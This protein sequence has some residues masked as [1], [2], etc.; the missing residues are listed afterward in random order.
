MSNQFALTE[1]TGPTPNQENQSLI[2][3]PHGVELNPLT[4]IEEGTQD[5]KTKGR[6]KKRTQAITNSNE[7]NLTNKKHNTNE[8]SRTPP[9][10]DYNQFDDSVFSQKHA[11]ATPS[12]ATNPINLNYSAQGAISAA[13]T[14]YQQSFLWQNEG[15]AFSITPVEKV[16]K[17]K[18]NSMAEESISTK[19]PVRDSKSH[20]GSVS[21][22]KAKSVAKSI[23][24]S[25]QTVQKGMAKISKR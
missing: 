15:K 8:D 14:S 18:K 11:S 1:I 24:P 20:K 19:N 9:F 5:N 6:R 17:V 12:G 23:L 21:T 13:N 16:R 22:S 25:I 2:S 4:S 7:N 10:Q 3:R